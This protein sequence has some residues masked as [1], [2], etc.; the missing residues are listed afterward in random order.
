VIQIL[1]KTQSAAG[2]TTGSL[3]ATLIGTAIIFSILEICTAWIGK[4]YKNQIKMLI[5][6]ISLDRFV[7]FYQYFKPK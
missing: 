7:N 3:T 6:G 4:N 1:P 2:N 5:E